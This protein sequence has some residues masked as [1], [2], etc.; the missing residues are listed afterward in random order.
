MH[1]KTRGETTTS[2]L[3]FYIESMNSFYGFHPL[4]LK[5]LAVFLTFSKREWNYLDILDKTSNIN[6]FIVTVF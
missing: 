2:R 5:I 6:I 3:E 1:E 4:K